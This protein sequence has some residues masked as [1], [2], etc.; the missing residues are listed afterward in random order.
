MV[1]ADFPAPTAP[2]RAAGIT[3][4]D[5]PPDAPMRREWA[6][7]CDAPDHPAVLTAW[8]LPGQSGDPRPR[9]GLRVDVDRRAARRPRRR[10][11]L[12]RQVA[13][14]GTRSGAPLL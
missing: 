7:V 4:V 13:A 6:V 11:G 10:P 5:L 3:M 12:R 9:A 2:A 8:E 1:F 14:A